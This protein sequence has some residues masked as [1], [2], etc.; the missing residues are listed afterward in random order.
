MQITNQYI[1]H[2]NKIRNTFHHVEYMLEFLI[3]LSRLLLMISRNYHNLLTYD[4]IL[5]IQKSYLW[6]ALI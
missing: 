1:F 5:A 4:W 3:D 6:L 2:E